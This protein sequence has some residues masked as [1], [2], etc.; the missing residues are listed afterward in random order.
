M[1]FF[2]SNV[3]DGNY[4]VWKGD[5][6]EEKGYW[7][8]YFVCLLFAVNW[9]RSLKCRSNPNLNERERIDFI[10]KLSLKDLFLSLLTYLWKF[11]T[12]YFSLLRESLDEIENRK[13]DLG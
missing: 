4:N 8:C 5:S 12:F 6:I 3:Y 1:F 7:S 2:I 10:L 9:K 13:K 11:F